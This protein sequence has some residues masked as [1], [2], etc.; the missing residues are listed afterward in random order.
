MPPVASTF[1]LYV[2]ATVPP[3][4]GELVTMAKGPPMVMLRGL[5]W[6]AGGIEESAA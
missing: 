1:A 6:V 5:V 4:G 3:G 2:A